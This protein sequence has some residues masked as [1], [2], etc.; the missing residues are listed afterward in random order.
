MI[1]NCFNVMEFIENESGG[2]DDSIYIVKYTVNSI[3]LSINS[4]F[5]WESLCDKIVEQFPQGD[6][7]F[8][9]IGLDLNINWR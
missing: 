3:V 8:S 6:F 7:E 2:F 4:C 1:L 9:V 5:D